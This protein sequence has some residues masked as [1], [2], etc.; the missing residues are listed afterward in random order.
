MNTNHLHHRT[1]ALA[2]LRRLVPARGLSRH[3]ARRVAERQAAMLLDFYGID[4]GP[5][6]IAVFATLPRTSVGLDPT[7]PTS[8]MSYWTGDEWRLV[9]RADEHPNRQR[10]SLAHEFKHV[11]DHPSRDLL[12]PDHAARE[13]TA[14]YFAACLLM[15]KVAIRRAWCAGIQDLDDLSERFM[16]ST[17][18]IQRRL[19]DL[20]LTDRM[21]SRRYQCARPSRAL[22]PARA[23]AIA[24]HP[25]TD[26]KS[27]QVT[28]TEYP[29]VNHEAAL[30]GLVSYPPQH[31]KAKVR[32]AVL[33]L[34]VSSTSQVNTDYDPEGIS[35]PAQRGS[36]TRKAT[37]IGDIEIVDEY[38]E[39]GRTGTNMAGRPAFQEMLRRI[40]QDRDIDV[41]IVYK[42]SRMNR[43]R[44]DDAMVM[45]QLRQYGV[46][47]VSA[48][49]MIDDTPEGQLLHGVLATINEFRSAS[50]GA[51][52]RDKMAEKARRGGTIGRAPIGYLN[53]KDT[54]EGREIATVAIDPERGPLVRQAF[55]LYATGSYSLA[56]LCDELT[57]R[58]LR[59]KPGRFPPGPISD[60]KLAKL[61]RDPYYRGIVTYKGDQYPG[62]HEP[63][64]DQE[65]FDTVQAELGT[66][67]IAGERQ[68][69]HD[70][71]LKGTLYCAARHRRGRES[72]LLVQKSTGRRG[73]TYYYF[74]CT[75]RQQGNCTERH[76]PRADVETAVEDH[77]RGLALDPELT[78]LITT[79]LTDTLSDLQTATR[80]ATRQ[81]N[82]RI[83]KLDRQ[84]ENLLDLIADAEID[85]A[86]AKTRLRRITAERETL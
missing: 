29:T 83:A 15:P 76:L 10:F 86:R 62:R 16:V 6:P 1:G 36:C 45:A 47:L 30:R 57:N 33:Y 73:G 54:F 26:P 60:S 82:A 9:A 32:R 80:E 21:R 72:R 40:R 5:I 18:A 77:Y 75:A 70:H 20:G 84:E 78:A 17:P 81:T 24:G 3:E 22:T 38:V 8:G 41:V 11:I 35:I 4:D 79:Q 71:Y 48:T 28:G 49:E 34:R 61:L 67:Q 44:F 19:V 59:T 7:L 27:P 42:L 68:R 31:P 2:E 53:T 69:V 46:T 64:I 43:N 12:Y 55:E 39:P 65:L 52:I 13:D 63:L 23:F 50:D 58:G 85:T 14:D 56:A 51:D 25:S 74:F 37:Q 66:R